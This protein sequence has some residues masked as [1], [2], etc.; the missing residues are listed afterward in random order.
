MV[1]RGGVDCGREECASMCRSLAHFI[2]H[3]DHDSPSVVDEACVLL[4]A[5]VKESEMPHHVV[6]QYVH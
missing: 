1:M 5:I 4:L 2:L 3:D 6:Y